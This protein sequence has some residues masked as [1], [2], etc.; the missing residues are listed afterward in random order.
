MIIGQKIKIYHKFPVQRLH[1]Q[2]VK[3]NVS[4]KDNTMNNNIFKKFKC[5]L[6]APLEMKNSNAII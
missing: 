4:L 3:G 1:L 5:Q 6:S 2:V